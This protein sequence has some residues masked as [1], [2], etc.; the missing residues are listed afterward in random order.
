M[1]NWVCMDNLSHQVRSLPLT[2]DGDAVSTKLC[3]GSYQIRKWPPPIPYSPTPFRVLFGAGGFVC[4]LFVCCFAEIFALW[5]DYLLIRYGAIFLSHD[6]SM[7]P[8]AFLSLTVVW[9]FFFFFCAWCFGFLWFCRQ[10]KQLHN[11]GS[12]MRKATEAQVFS[13]RAHGG[14]WTWFSIQ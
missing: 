5:V 3:S 13:F 1:K 11:L 14:D 9:F 8:F 6:I 7:Q 12:L 4:L 10:R 2:P